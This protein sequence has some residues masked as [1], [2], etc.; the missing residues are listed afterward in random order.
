MAKSTGKKTGRVSSRRLAQ[1]L[2][3]DG[4]FTV[5][6]ETGDR[7]QVGFAIADFGA[8]ERIPVPGA[9]VSDIERY[10]Q[11]EAARL[12][13]DRKFF[14]GWRNDDEGR[15]HEADYLDV[16]TV[17]GS[18]R[19]AFV[20][21]QQTAQRAVM[22]LASFA[23]HSVP[24]PPGLPGTKRTGMS[25]EKYQRAE[26]KNRELG[27]SMIEHQLHGRQDPAQAKERGAAIADALIE[28]EQL[29]AEVRGRHPRAQVKRG[30]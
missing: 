1:D 5:H 18:R 13:G 27:R 29:H 28:R 20:Q 14:G 22:D 4:G 12:A 7:P 21:G 15:G 17:V 16:S 30:K 24:F 3:T 10:R 11:R 26:A 6:E 19:E 23:E 9:S 2:A 25:R 8:E